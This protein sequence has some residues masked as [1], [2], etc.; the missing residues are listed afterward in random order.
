MEE[1]RL[2]MNYHMFN[3]NT[4][5]IFCDGSIKKII[6]PDGTPE[7]IGCAGAYACCGIVSNEIEKSCTVIRGATN[8]ITELMAIY[9]ALVI[10]QKH[11]HEF[12]TINFISDSKIN[13]MG[14]R[15]WIFKWIVPGM[16]QLC[17]SSGTPKNQPELLKNIYFILQNKLNVN[18]YHINGHKNPNIESH[19]KAAYKTFKESNHLQHP[20]EH[21]LITNLCIG[22]DIVDKFTGVVIEEK[23]RLFGAVG[24]YVPT[25]IDPDLVPDEWYLPEPQP[26]PLIRHVYYPF[27]VE[28]YRK[29]IN[30]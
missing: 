22:N 19:M 27:D 15:E 13:I 23:M 20:I 7:T 10:A 9:E 14:L 6:H 28:L 4:L 18:F 26:Q 11:R 21:K 30:Q 2:I 17:S 3:R 16:S 8:N 29:L 25:N 24:S 1:K 5:N 12:K